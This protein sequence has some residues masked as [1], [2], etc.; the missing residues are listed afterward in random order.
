[1]MAI[2]K[3]IS[4]K[5]SWDYLFPETEG[6]GKQYYSLKIIEGEIV[7]T[8]SRI[9]EQSIFVLYTDFVLREQW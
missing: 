4:P 9:K 6:W 8:I 2:V 3:T 5:W 7:S 1:M